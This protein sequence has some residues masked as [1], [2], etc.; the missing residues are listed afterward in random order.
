MARRS[1]K[2]IER[3]GTVRER[4]EMDRRRGVAD[5]APRSAD[6]CAQCGTSPWHNTCDSSKGG[7]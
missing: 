7:R 3:H 2:Q 1:D 6:S 5:P 4:M